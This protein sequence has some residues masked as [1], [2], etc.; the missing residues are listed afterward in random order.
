[1]VELAESLYPPTLVGLSPFKQ[2]HNCL[3]R[4]RSRAPRR[5]PAGR[6]VPLVDPRRLL[7]PQHP[8]DD[9]RDP[10]GARRRRP[11]QP[12]EDLPHLR[13]RHRRGFPPRPATAPGSATTK[14][15]ATASCGGASPPSSAPRT[16]PAR[17]PPS[18]PR[19]PPRSGAV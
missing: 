18:P 16:D 4:V 2:R 11:Q 15:A 3:T 13:H 12:G 5:E 7:P 10:L 19:R 1:M 14:P 8:A 9:L 17:L 6:L